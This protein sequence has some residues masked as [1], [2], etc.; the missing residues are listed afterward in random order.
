MCKHNLKMI[1]SSMI[2]YNGKP[3]EI[4]VW[5]CQVCKKILIIDAKTDRKIT[6]DGKMGEE[7][8]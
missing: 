6:V 4:Y 7:I 3:T 8:K 5:E 1:R 2:L